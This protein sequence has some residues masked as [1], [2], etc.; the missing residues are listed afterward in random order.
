MGIACGLQQRYGYGTTHLSVNVR[1]ACV[2]QPRAQGQ[3][4]EMLP[5]HT[6]W[7]WPCTRNVIM[8]KLIGEESISHLVEEELKKGIN[9]HSGEA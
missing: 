7:D 8:F 3:Q 6:D 9:S 2:T 1:E 5:E 4:V